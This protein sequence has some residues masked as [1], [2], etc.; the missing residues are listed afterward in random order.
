MEKRKEQEARI[1][2]IILNMDSSNK[3]CA[4]CENENVTSVSIN[5][6]TVIC[7]DCAEKHKHLSYWISFIKSFT[8]KWDDYLLKFI[9][10]GGNSRYLKFCKDYK[11]ENIQSIDRYKTKGV[12]Y[13]RLILKSEVMGFDP[14]D[15]INVNS[16]GEILENIENNY[17]EF[18]N[19]SYVKHVDLEKLEKQFEIDKKFNEENNAGL[20]QTFSGILGNFGKKL[21]EAK[22]NIVGK[23]NEKLNEEGGLMEKM[24]GMTEGVKNK[25]YQFMG[26]TE[27]LNKNDNN[28]QKNVKENINENQNKNVENISFNDLKEL[29]EQ[30]NKNLTNKKIEDSNKNNKEEKIIVDDKKEEINS[31]EEK[32]DEVENQENITNKNEETNENENEKIENKIE[33]IDKKEEIIQQNEKSNFNEEKI[34]NNKI[35]E[36]KNITVNQ[37]K[38]TTKII[39]NKEENLNEI[40]NEESK[41]INTKKNEEKN[42]K[43]KLD[44]ILKE[45][46]EEEHKMPKNPEEI[47]KKLD[48]IINEK[49]EKEKNK[50]V[51]E[52]KIDI[53]KTQTNESNRISDKED[54]LKKETLRSVTTSEMFLD[55]N[56]LNEILGD[57]KEEEFN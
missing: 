50:K 10:N 28:V 18:E 39:E 24:K 45:E 2:T 26:K 29:K 44:D 32:L 21:N 42:N 19:Y 22:D 1:K 25:Y 37:E 30:K 53:K 38:Q 3:K 33:T 16:A 56:Q 5:N 36:E 43:T 7:S 9:K 13:Y 47:K 23:V 46:M 57:D 31:N 27:E 52:K 49:E 14:P 8:E 11:I 17:P 51:D 48:E 40:K 35:N 55:E 4:D 34:E 15:N 20:F 54:I 6:G 12:E 41:E